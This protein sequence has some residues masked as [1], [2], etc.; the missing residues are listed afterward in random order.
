MGI[1]GEGKNMFARDIKSVRYMLAIGPF[2]EGAAASGHF[3]VTFKN[4]II[5]PVEGTKAEYM[6]LLDA[7][8][9]EQ[10]KKD[11]ELRR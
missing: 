9:R 5:S 6:K 2:S 10:S 7:L 4:G 8:V 11:D 1:D 3:N